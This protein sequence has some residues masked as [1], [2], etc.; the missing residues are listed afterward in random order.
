MRD[1]GGVRGGGR[2][3]G[4]HEVG[5]P[6]QK[7]LT[8]HPAYTSLCTFLELCCFPQNTLLIVEIITE[9][10]L[11]TAAADIQERLGYLNAMSR[12]QWSSGC[13][14]PA[15]YSGQESC[16]CIKR[17]HGH[18]EVCLRRKVFIVEMREKV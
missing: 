8:Q 6:E 11:V 12:S 10:L 9:F 7:G 18:S 16:S 3:K 1:W 17:G 2:I 15:L 14:M 5:P 4:G 13:S